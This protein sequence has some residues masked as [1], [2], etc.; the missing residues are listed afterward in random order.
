MIDL[1]LPLTRV[2]KF[3][4]QIQLSLHPGDRRSQNLLAIFAALFLTLVASAQS[5]EKSQGSAQ[6]KVSVLSKFWQED[7]KHYNLASLDGSQFSKLGENELAFKEGSVLIECEQD[8]TVSLPL[9]KI[10]MPAHAMALIRVSA[11]AERIYCLLESVKII[12]KNKSC[13]LRCGEE[14]LLTDHLPQALEFAG[15]FD[16]GVRQIRSVEIDEQLK[17]SSME[18]SLIQSMERE[19]LLAQI[20]HSGHKHDR[21]LREKLIK[22]AAV[23]NYVT[24]R[25]GPYSGY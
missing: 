6:K 12:A 15:E 3:L 8:S 13:D 10:E 14:A 23:I 11:G 2:L 9:S 22:A 4:K 21:F 24:N 16:V 20:T 25:H 18:F 7:G 5:K 1:K 17:L 19:P